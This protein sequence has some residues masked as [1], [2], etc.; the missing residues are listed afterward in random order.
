M[1][2]SLLTLLIFSI[3]GCQS[4]TMPDDSPSSFMENV[5][6][7][8]RKDVFEF[9]KDDMVTPDPVENLP[10]I[11]VYTINT[12]IIIEGQP[13]KVKGVE[14][15]DQ[16]EGMWW[17]RKSEDILRD[18]KNAEAIYKDVGLKFHVYEM[19]YR[20]WTPDV[21]DHFLDANRYPFVMT[22]VYMLPNGFPFEGYSSAPWEQFNRGI[23]ISYDADTWTVAHE[24]GHYF[25]LLHPFMD[26][27]SENDFVDDTL[28]QQIKYCFGEFDS[29][30]NCQNIMQYC[31]HEPKEITPGQVTRMQRFLRAKRLSHLTR[32]VTDIF[33]QGQEIPELDSLRVQFNLNIGDSYDSVQ[34]EKVEIESKKP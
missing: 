1:I 29:T 34:A 4:P 19:S 32:D 30:P 27:Y 6:V 15:Y 24:I 11:D 12:R 17:A 22:L 14:G 8:T 31:N 13:I 16:V 25:G 23:V 20:E 3:S 7:L 26:E 10:E 9:G 21:I 2:R 28:E 5:T 18:L 33:L